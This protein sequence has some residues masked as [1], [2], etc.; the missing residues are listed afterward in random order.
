MTTATAMLTIGT[1]AAGQPVTLP[2]DVLTHTMA[3]LAKKGAG[4]TYT[5]GVIEEEFAKAGLPFVVLDPVGVHYG[6]RSNRNGTRSDYSVVV[7]GGEHGDI[8]IER[9]MG[10][11]DALTAMEYLLGQDAYRGIN[12]TSVALSGS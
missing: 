4:K 12:R 2:P 3:I 11:A 9:K 7:F 6:I 5:A 10:A 8:P 1:D